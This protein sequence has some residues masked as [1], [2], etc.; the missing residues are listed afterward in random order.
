MR[1]S[2]GNQVHLASETAK[3]QIRNAKQASKGESALSTARADSSVAPLALLKLKHTFSKRLNMETLMET[4][5]ETLMETLMGTLMETL[6]KTPIE[7]LMETI[8]EMLIWTL[9]E[10]LIWRRS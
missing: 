9:M 10:T 4:L 8:M 2:R 1:N 7:T 3:W 5:K 6:M